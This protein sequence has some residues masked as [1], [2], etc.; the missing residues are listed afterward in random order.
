M[1]PVLVQVVVE[2][3]ETLRRCGRRTDPKAYLVQNTRGGRMSASGGRDRLRGRRAGEQRTGEQGPRAAAEHDT[4]SLRRT[5]ISIE[6][7]ASEGDVKWVMGRSG[8]P[9]RR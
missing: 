2:H 9:T 6:L 4:H 7:I 5:Y 3:I 1:S 8:T